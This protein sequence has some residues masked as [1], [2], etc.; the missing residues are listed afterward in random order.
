MHELR[1]EIVNDTE[2]H[3]ILLL[4]IK[5]KLFPRLVRDLEDAL[6]GIE[7]S[8]AQEGE[9]L[10]KLSGIY[11]SPNDRH[12]DLPRLR[13][14][15]L[16]AFVRRNHRYRLL[17]ILSNSVLIILLNSY[18]EQIPIVSILTSYLTAS[19]I[20]RPVYLAPRTP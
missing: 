12:Q 20:L 2:A 1:F 11:F 6:V 14:N 18:P 19:S 10:I 13:G 8:N 15:I 17:I 5:N 16:D 9:S 3:D 7:K 4:R